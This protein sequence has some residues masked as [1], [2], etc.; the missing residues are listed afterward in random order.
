MGVSGFQYSFYDCDSLILG[1]VL[2]AS[3]PLLRGLQHVPRLSHSTLDLR[4]ILRMADTDSVLEAAEF[5][6]VL[7]ENAGIPFLPRWC[8]VPVAVHTYA[9]DR[10]FGHEYSLV[11]LVACQFS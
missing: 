1:V 4:C 2:D 5:V 8:P 11:L 9:M 3:N 7:P 6:S 10:L